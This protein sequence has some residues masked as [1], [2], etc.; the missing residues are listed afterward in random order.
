M[1]CSATKNKN[2]IAGTPQDRQCVHC[3]TKIV[4]QYW[5]PSVEKLV[6]GPLGVKIS[7]FFWGGGEG[8]VCPDWTIYWILG[9]FSKPLATIN[10]PKSPTFLGN[11]CKGVKIYHFWATFIDIWWFYSGHTG[12]DS[13]TICTN[14]FSHKKQLYPLKPFW[15]HWLLMKQVL[16]LQDQCDRRL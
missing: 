15:R 16:S 13:D 4:L 8:S 5:S 14:T 11:F 2:G 7:A 12:R 9:K 6:N 1:F 3:G 10:L